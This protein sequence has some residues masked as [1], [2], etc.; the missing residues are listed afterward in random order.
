M[1]DGYDLLKMTAEFIRARAELDKIEREYERVR[2]DVYMSAGV[3]GF[4]NADSR[5]AAVVQIMEMEH[6]SLVDTLQDLRG[7]S[8]EAFYMREAVMETRKY[9]AN[10]LKGATQ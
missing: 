4:G 1:T 2:A 5:N 7:R 10:N 9:I 8:R 3:Q 6:K